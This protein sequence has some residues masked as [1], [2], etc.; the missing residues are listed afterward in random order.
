MKEQLY[1]LGIAEEKIRLYSKRPDI[2]TPFLKNLSEDFREES[3]TGACAEVGVF[4]GE[5]AHKINKFFPDSNLHLYDTFEGFAEDDIKYEH[6]VGRKDVTEGQF[7]DT[8]IEIVMGNMLHPERV[9]IHRGV[10]PDTMQELGEKFCFVKIDL[11]L[12]APTEA[13][14]EVFGSLMVKGGIILV[15]DYFGSQYPSI[16]KVVRKFMEEHP[17]LHKIPIGDA[18]SIAITG[19]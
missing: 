14:L 8:S 10:F 19:F 12:Y 5:S 9:V 4:R 1:K 6:A 18:M 2:L 7:N 15:H 16:K 3:I 17:E 11:D 13:A